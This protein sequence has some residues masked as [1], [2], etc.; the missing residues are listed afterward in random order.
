MIL[1]ILEMFGNVLNKN[2]LKNSKSKC[3]LLSDKFDVS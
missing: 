2:V 3:Y 1:Q